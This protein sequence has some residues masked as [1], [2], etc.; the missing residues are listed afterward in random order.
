MVYPNRKR[1]GAIILLTHSIFHEDLIGHHIQEFLYSAVEEHRNNGIQR[2]MQWD[3]FTRLEYSYLILKKR[4]VDAYL[5]FFKVVARKHEYLCPK[6]IE[7]LLRSLRMYNLYPSC[8]DILQTIR[9]MHTLRQTQQRPC[10]CVGRYSR[11]SETCIP[12]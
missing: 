6:L 2:M 1:Q 12:I 10:I 5:N 11:A 3:I 7:Q 9:S 4:P 8:T